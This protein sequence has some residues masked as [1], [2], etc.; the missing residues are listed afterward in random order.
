MAYRYG[1]EPFPTSKIL[2]ALDYTEYV[3]L[4]AD[5]K[6]VLTM[7]ISAGNINFRENSSMWNVIKA[8]F[9]EGTATWS[10]L[11]RSATLEYDVSP[12]I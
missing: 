12:P 6:D 5:L 10:A 2:D 3:A 11:V 7:I 8:I 9:P 4:A 1:W